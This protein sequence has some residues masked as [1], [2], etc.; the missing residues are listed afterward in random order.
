MLSMRDY[1]GWF[2]NRARDTGYVEDDE[3]PRQRVDP[4]SLAIL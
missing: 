1:M 2:A 4:R 3:A